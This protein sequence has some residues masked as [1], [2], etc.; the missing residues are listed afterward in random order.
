MIKVDKNLCIGCGACVSLCP[1]SFAFDADYKAEC[2]SQ[3]IL[4][5]TKEAAEACP[6]EAIAI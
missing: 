4:P 2:L 1:E 5:C 3:E 6:V